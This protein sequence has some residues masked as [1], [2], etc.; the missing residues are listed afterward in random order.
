MEADQTGSVLLEEFA[1]IHKTSSKDQLERSAI[2]MYERQAKVGRTIGDNSKMMAWEDL[3]REKRDAVRLDLYY[4]L[5]DALAAPGGQSAI[6]LSGGGIRSAA[7]A[8]GILQGLARHGLLSRFHYLS[9]VSGGGY[10]G[11]WLTA[12]AS[13]AATNRTKQPDEISFTA[14]E[15]TLAA[16][17]TGPKP[18][19]ELGFPDA[20]DGFG[21]A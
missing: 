6:C 5:V 16:A 10:M 3:S 18:L 1:A 8:L 19:H 9:T 4:Q 14:I 17:G 11:G 21:V 2:E 15:R 12:W 20:T 13:R 7:F